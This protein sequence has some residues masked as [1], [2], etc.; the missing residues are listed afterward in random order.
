MNNDFNLEQPLLK[1]KGKT[2]DTE[3]SVRDSF[4][5]CFLYG[6]TGAGKSTSAAKKILTEFL[7]HQYGG[8]CLCAKTDELETIFTYCKAANRMDDVVI[9]GPDSGHSFDFIGYESQQR[10]AGI[11]ITSNLVHVLKVIL[12]A[13]EEKSNS[14]RDDPFWETTMEMVLENIIG[15]SILAYGTV[16]L[17]QIFDITSTIPK[18]G[19]KL[20]Q[21]PK[22]N[23]Y[24]H[25]FKL[26][27]KKINEQIAADT[28]LNGINDADEY[29]RA[30]LK[31]IPDARTL[32]KIDSFFV[33]TFKN[34]SEK[35][36]SV[37]MLVLLGF[38]SHLQSEPI[39]SLLCN[40]TSTITPEDCLNG[41]IV[42][43]NLPTQIYHEAGMQSQCLIK[44]IFQ[45]AFER[46]N[47]N[48]SGRP[49]FIY[50]D[51]CQTFLH[52]K[53]SDFQN[54]A[55]SSRV[56]VVYITQNIH[57]L[58]SSMGG[59]NSEHRV[60]SF[61]STLCT[62]IFLAN[63]DVETNL[64]ASSLIGKGYRKDYSESSTIAGK[65]SITESVKNELSEMVRP[66]E[67]AYL[68]TG[69]PLNEGLVEGYVIL[70]GKTFDT[71]FNFK[72]VTFKQ[73]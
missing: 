52:P 24:A 49:L 57:N 68:K 71:G 58:Y 17:E 14:K 19:A 13:S 34:V 46:R 12:S 47:V 25:A 5:G 70:Q 39:Y 21:E 3:W 51:E 44:Y 20:D 4:Q 73:S 72:K 64:Y 48:H 7:K 41:K 23:S 61:M 26:A 45:R 9:L 16:S 54:T 15:L 63:T 22:P 31:K 43:V 6:A 18:A 30:I 29:E 60:K 56:A 69:G 8:L 50:A 35:T 37:V 67:F 62:K 53:D 38:L 10:P 36:R 2:H 59:N 1:F 33:D 28:S 32:R 65:L 55:R 11:T 42:I 66:E 40:G 27:Q